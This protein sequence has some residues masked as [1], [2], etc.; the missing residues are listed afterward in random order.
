MDKKKILHIAQS[1]GGVENYLHM[2]LAH[3]P[4]EK[5]D[6][7]LVVSEDYRKNEYK[8]KDLVSKIQYVPMKRDID[9]KSI[10]ISV[11]Q[12]KKILKETK[13]DIVY[14][15]SSMAGGVGRIATLFNKK[16]KKIYNA[17]GWYFNAQIGNKKRKFYEILERLLAI[18][19]D[20]IVNI[21]QSEYES[22]MKRKIAKPEKMCI[23]DNGIDFEKF[24]SC[25]KYRIATRKKL[26][27]KDDDIV[28]GA[29]GR[30]AEQK[31]PMTLIKAFSRVHNNYSNTKLIFVGAGDLEEDIVSY[32]KKNNLE[33]NIIITGWIEDVEKY[34]PAFDI[35]SLTS[36]WEGFGLVIIEY[37]ACKK[38]IV[39]TRVGGI[40]NIIDSDEKGYL[41]EIE[42]DEE[43]SDKICDYIKN[44]E[45]V[46]QMTQ[47]NFEYARQ[48]FNIEQ[49]VEKHKKIF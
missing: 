3:M 16:V 23:I 43:L 4:K 7:I 27:I 28:I 40:E 29:V 35:A 38:P 2:L 11:K 10:I 13:P 39:A 8:F 49:V 6:N 48:R 21:S 15:H 31:D 42:D 34:I 14:M 19:T 47:N 45:L 20:M 41:I 36:K 44:K 5:Y 1:A 25:E 18:N 46:E 37:M 33:Q 12:V 32:A 17:H 9:L 30:L 22:A 26:G 24:K